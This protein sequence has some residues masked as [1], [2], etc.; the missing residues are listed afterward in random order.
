M[1]CASIV[2]VDH[3]GQT[4]NSL[5]RGEANEGEQ[6]S[7]VTDAYDGFT[8]SQVNPD[9]KKKKAEEPLAL[10]KPRPNL[11]SVKRDFLDVLKERY[12]ENKANTICM[13]IFAALILVAVVYGASYIAPIN[14]PGYH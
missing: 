3:G 13:F 1:F 10:A 9:N 14:D 11:N 2:A 12:Q 6:M 8:P 7:K 4:G 5:K